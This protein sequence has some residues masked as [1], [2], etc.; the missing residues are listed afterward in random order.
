MPLQERAIAY[1]LYHYDLESPSQNKIGGM[2]FVILPN[3]D[4]EWEHYRLAFEACAMASFINE[5]GG[6]L[7]YKSLTIETY[8]K[9][10][11]AM[12]SA[13]QDPDVVCEDATLAA[14]LLL[15]LFE[16]LN[17]TTGEQES[18]RN[19]VQGAIELARGRGRK[20]IDT[21]IGQM[22]FRATRTLM[23]IY[24]L[25]TLE[26]K[27]EK[28][29]WWSGDD[30]CTSTQKLCVGVASL[31][32]KATALLG[33][34]GHEDEVE[35]EVML[36]RC[37]AHDRTCKARWDELSK[38]TQ[39]ISSNNTDP[40]LLM[41]LN[42]LTC[43]RILLNSIIMRCATWTYK[44]PNYQTSEEYDGA[45]SALAEIILHSAKVNEQQLCWAGEAQSSFAELD[46]QLQPD[47]DSS[48]CAI[49]K[50]IEDN[51]DL[52]KEKPLVGLQPLALIWSLKC[53]TDD[54]I[55]AVD[56]RLQRILG[57]RG[58]LPLHD[59][60]ASMPSYRFT[61]ETPCSSPYTSEVCCTDFRKSTTDPRKPGVR[62][63]APHPKRTKYT[64]EDRD[65][66]LDLYEKG[67]TWQVLQDRFPGHTLRSL[68]SQ[69]RVLRESKFL[70]TDDEDRTLIRLR[71]EECLEFGVI[72][73]QLHHR[74]VAV[75]RRY[76]QLRPGSV[77]NSRPVD[78]DIKRLVDLRNQGHYWTDIQDTFRGCSKKRLRKLY[79]EYK[80]HSL[81][82]SLKEIKVHP[83]NGM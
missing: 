12:H 36:K 17:P 19:H 27:K 45:C 10:L 25:A 37:Q 67:T 43:A 6:Q 53:L 75:S 18:W 31:S 81:A 48:G 28:E 5:T 16:C 71:E 80:S 74:P 46:V 7:E 21:R 26:D 9:A 56:T 35:V 57:I 54:Q 42:M 73:Q 50:W 52:R 22:L 63:S 24:S 3:S 60:R 8:N 65:A 13:L 23:V 64:E 79:S 41:L 14:V 72:A 61:V 83:Q 76:K 33:P 68:K 62:D 30:E 78:I 29:L 32:A 2:G 55:I 20:Q 51:R 40:W 47:R 82:A 44:V 38:S 49:N 58:A 4:K 59:H 69:V 77:I 70:F 11:T 1:F 39:G 34:S 15:A 66:L